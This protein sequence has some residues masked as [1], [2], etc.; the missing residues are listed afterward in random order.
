MARA[1]QALLVQKTGA[2]LPAEMEALNHLLKAQ[3]EAKAHYEC[4]CGRLLTK[5]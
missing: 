1:E 2:A 3:S 4:P 5:L